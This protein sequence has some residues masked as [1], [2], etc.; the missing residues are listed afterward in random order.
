MEERDEDDD[1]EE[2]AGCEAVELTAEVTNVGLEEETEDSAVSAVMTTVCPA[3][4]TMATPPLLLLLLSPEESKLA[5]EEEEKPAEEEKAEALELSPAEL[6]S[7]AITLEEEAS[8]RTT[9]R[10]TRTSEAVITTVRERERKETV[11][12]TR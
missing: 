4:P 3:L 2:V 7:C 10:A 6:L 9:V 1:G 12:W 11:D 5:A 8:S